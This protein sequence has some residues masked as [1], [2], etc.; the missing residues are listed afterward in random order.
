MF[1]GSSALHCDSDKE[2]NHIWGKVRLLLLVFDSEFEASHH[3]LDRA[4]I[5][6]SV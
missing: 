3:Y 5:A 4:G 2:S 6:Q 1:E